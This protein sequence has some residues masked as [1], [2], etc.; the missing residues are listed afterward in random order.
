MFQSVSGTTNQ[1]TKMK[2]NTTT[3]EGDVIGMRRIGTF[4]SMADAMAHLNDEYT[5]KEEYIIYHDESESEFTI[6]WN[7]L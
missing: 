1:N 3:N 5:C 4:F 2:Y 6:Y 7:N